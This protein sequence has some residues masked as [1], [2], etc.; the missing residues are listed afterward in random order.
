MLCPRGRCPPS[1]AEGSEF[2]LIIKASATSAS[3][4]WQPSPRQPLARSQR[5][6]LAHWLM[7]LAHQSLLEDTGALQPHVNCLGLDSTELRSK[8]N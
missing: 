2:Q 7:L 3:G 4:P 8:V 5:L 1:P 6:A